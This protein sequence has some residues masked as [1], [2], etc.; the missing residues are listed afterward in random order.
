MQVYFYPLQILGAAARIRHPCADILLP[1]SREIFIMAIRP[2]TRQQKSEE[3]RKAIL[4]SALKLFSIYGYDTVTV[5]DIV[6]AIGMSK[7]SFYNLFRSKSDLI[8][9]RS[10]VLGKDVMKEY[11]ALL[12]TDG[13][14]ST[15]SLCKIRDFIRIMLETSIGSGNQSFLSQMF[16]SVMKDPPEDARNYFEQH[17]TDEIVKE[18]ISL[19]QRRNEIR[20]DIS[21][22]EILR[23]IH[24]FQR[25]LLLEWCYKKGK[26][27]IISRNQKA[28]DIFCKGLSA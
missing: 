4:D 13:Y 3:N 9:Y 16:I 1:L 18:V 17:Q 15:H 2:T 24:I 12:A 11:S 26:Y 14:E 27:D 20:Q 6:G 10:E 21:C 28:I 22:D 23:S 19:G 5:N 8:I 25:S 7:G